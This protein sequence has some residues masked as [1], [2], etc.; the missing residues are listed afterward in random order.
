MNLGPEKL[1]PMSGEHTAQHPGD[2]NLF[3]SVFASSLKKEKLLL[4]SLHE[5]YSKKKIMFVQH[6]IVVFVNFYFLSRVEKKT[7][8]V[9]KQNWCSCVDWNEK[10]KDL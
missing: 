5:V 6:W 9:N 7:W 8:Y 2:W 4:T 10:K 3:A 1:F